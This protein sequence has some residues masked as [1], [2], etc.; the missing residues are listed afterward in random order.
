MLNALKGNMDE[1]LSKMTDT[2]DN[3][4]DEANLH[5]CLMNAHVVRGAE[6]VRDCAAAVP[7]ALNWLAWS[8]YDMLT[9]LSFRLEIWHSFPPQD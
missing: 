4:E 7:I 3:G 8:K 9:Y 1:Y 2:A 5:K 6:E